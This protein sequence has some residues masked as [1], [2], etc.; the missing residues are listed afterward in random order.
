M[1]GTLQQKPK[2]IPEQMWAQLRQADLI[3]EQDVVECQ[4]RARQRIVE[5]GR[6]FGFSESELDAF[7][8]LPLLAGMK[9]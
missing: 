6:R 7:Y 9:K 8:I 3:T 1:T 4:S 5:V 2:I